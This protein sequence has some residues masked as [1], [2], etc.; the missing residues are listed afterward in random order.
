LAFYNGCRSHSALG[1]Q[2]PIEFEREFFN[3]AA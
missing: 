2:T 1:Y 3:N